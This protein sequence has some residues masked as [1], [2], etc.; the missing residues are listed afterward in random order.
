MADG[1]PAQQQPQ[2]QPPQPQQPQPQGTTSTGTAIGGTGEIKSVGL[3]NL[4]GMKS[5]EDLDR[6]TA[7]SSV[8]LVLVPQSLAPKLATIPT[9]STGGTIIVPDGQRLNVLTG[10]TTMTG[11]ALAG[12]AGEDAAL[13][14]VGQLV[15]TSPVEKVGYQQLIVAGQVIAPR[16]SEGALGARIGQLLG[17]TLY[18]PYTEGA[19]VEQIAGQPLGGGVL[20]NVAGQETD[21]LLSVGDLVIT[22][23][24]P[25][26]GYGRLVVVGNLVAP[27]DSES[28]LAPYV[29]TTGRAIYYSGQ[30][31][32]FAGEDRFSRDFFDLLDGPVTLVLT[33]K[34]TVEPDVP[35][36]LLR[37]KVTQI[38]LT[39]ELA[40]PKDLVP[41]LQVLAADKVGKIAVLA[42]KNE[43]DEEDEEEGAP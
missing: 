26:L 42:D 1:V 4:T 33:G 38:V 13:V 11:E 12:P 30:P 41:V 10:Q 3:L 21:I 24:V 31:R 27:K 18:Y 40:A 9:A 35:R 23:P 8:G 17:Q 7:I 37:Q 2:P 19:R 20:A 15:V 5:P 36:D 6:I 43:E 32:F 34:F 16:G 39:G 25:K 28:V 22:S 29:W 14:V